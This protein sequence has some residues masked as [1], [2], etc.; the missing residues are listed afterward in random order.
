MAL[1]SAV[2]ALPTFNVDEKSVEAG[3][4]LSSGD[5]AASRPSSADVLSI[6]LEIDRSKADDAAAPSTTTSYVQT[7]TSGVNRP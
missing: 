7:F 2:A 3:D 6:N 4:N 5:Q 1:L